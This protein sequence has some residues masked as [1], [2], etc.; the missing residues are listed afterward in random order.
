MTIPM[1]EVFL[2]NNGKWKV[3]SEPINTTDKLEWFDSLKGWP[4]TTASISLEGE[5]KDCRIYL[6]S[7]NRGWVEWHAF[8]PPLV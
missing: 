3:L 7:P 4:T 8:T 1:I 5:T 6:S 2:S